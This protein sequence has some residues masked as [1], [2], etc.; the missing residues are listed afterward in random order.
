MIQHPA[1]VDQAIALEQLDQPA[2]AARHYRLAL[3]GQGLDA[4]ARRFATE[5][6]GALGGIR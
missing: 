6:A 5:R 4:D 2:Q 3:Q 1:N